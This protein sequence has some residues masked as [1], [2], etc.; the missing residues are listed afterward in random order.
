MSLVTAARHELARMSCRPSGIT[1][2]S[3]C[4]TNLSHPGIY[5]WV[6]DAKTRAHLAS[7][8]M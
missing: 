4:D 8:I 2:S 5:I 7:A 1:A 6:P 3:S